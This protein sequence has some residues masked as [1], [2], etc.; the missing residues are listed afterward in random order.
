MPSLKYEKVRYM[1]KKQTYQY[2]KEYIESEGYQ[3]LS[4]EYK[5]AN[6]YLL[7]K[8]PNP[9]HK[10]YEVTFNNFKHRHSRCRECR[11][12]K[13]REQRSF[14]YEDVK[15]YI[16]SFNYILLSKD[17]KNAYTE[18]TL[19]CPNNHIYKTKFAIFKYDGCRCPICNIS[20]GERKIIDWLNNNNIEYIYNEEYFNDLLSPLGNPLRPDFIIEDI[21]VWIEYDG[22]FHYMKKYEDDY[23]ENI[24]VNNKL[25]DNYAIKNKWKLIRIPYWDFNRIEEILEKEIY[26]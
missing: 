17:Y 21:R 6:D 10:S 7:V 9:N 14:S 22:E 23:H 1:G 26:N 4:E 5:G 25:K 18:L 2:V 3:L 12:E 24:L 13:Y 16:E 20:K 8:C 15:K 11:D 19:L